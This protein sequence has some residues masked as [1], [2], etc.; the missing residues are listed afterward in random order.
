MKI[1]NKRQWEVD[2][3]ANK[4]EGHLNTVIRAGQLNQIDANSK[5]AASIY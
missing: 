5:E 1:D 4:T 2:K 3:I